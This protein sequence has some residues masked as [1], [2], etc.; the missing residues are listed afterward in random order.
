MNKELNKVVEDAVEKTKEP[1]FVKSLENVQGDESDIIILSI[2]FRK[3]AAGRAVVIGPIARENGQRRLNVAVSRSKEK[4][5]VISTIRRLKEHQLG[6]ARFLCATPVDID[7]LLCY[8][9]ILPIR[10]E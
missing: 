9:H 8:L 5:I 10:E 4:M 2:G 6:H 1:W 3:N 7:Y